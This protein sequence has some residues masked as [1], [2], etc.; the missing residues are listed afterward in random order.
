VGVQSCSRGRARFCVVSVELEEADASSAPEA[1]SADEASASD[2]D[3][4]EEETEE[5]EDVAGDAGDTVEVDDD[6]ICFPCVLGLFLGQGVC[7]VVS[8][9][10]CVCQKFSVRCEHAIFWNLV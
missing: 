1:D 5:S 4:V 10:V 2:A 9:C 3:S 7:M 6:G 8:V